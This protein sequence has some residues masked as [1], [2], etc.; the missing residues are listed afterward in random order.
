MSYSPSSDESTEK[1]ASSNI[2]EIPYT[3]QEIISIGKHFEN[4]DIKLFENA[5][6]VQ[7]KERASD[8]PIIHLAIHGQADKVDRYNSK[9]IFRSD[10][11]TE[12]DGDLLAY[13]LYNLDLANTQLTVLSACETGLGKQVEGEGI[14]SMA[15]GFAFA[16]CPSIVM[17]LWRANDKS[18]FMLMDL[19]YENLAKGLNKDKALQMAKVDFINH[20]NEYDAHPANWAT[21]IALGNNEPIDFEKGN[22]HLYLYMSLVALLFVAVLFYANKRINH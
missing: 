18:T 3:A 5:T 13:E 12:E 10:K 8:F 11:S 21:F 1:M 16:G 9:L 19:F 2:N 7:F 4:V 20:T 14:F 17:S 15:R 22:N 6:E